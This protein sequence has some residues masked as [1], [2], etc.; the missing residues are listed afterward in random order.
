MPASPHGKEKRRS[1]AKTAWP[2][3]LLLPVETSQAKP[4]PA[5]EQAQ[6]ATRFCCSISS[7]WLDAHGNCHG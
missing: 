6:R 7:P 3:D 4:C 1:K 2:A 5:R